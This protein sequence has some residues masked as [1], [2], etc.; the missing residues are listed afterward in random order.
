MTFS[1]YTRPVQI[2]FGHNRYAEASN[3]MP[4]YIGVIFLLMSS[5]CYDNSIGRTSTRN[6][7]F[8]K[9]PTEPF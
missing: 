1:V 5:H 4:A 8:H 3:I 2:N 7:N 9:V 6:K